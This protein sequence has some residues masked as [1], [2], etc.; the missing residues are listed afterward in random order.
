MRPSSW[1]T[2]LPL[3]SGMSNAAMILRANATSAAAA[4]TRR[5]QRRSDRDGSASC[6]R[7]RAAALL[8]FASKPSSVAEVVVDAVE[9]GEAVGARGRQRRRQPVEP[10]VRSAPVARAFP[11]RDRWCPSR[12]T[13]R[14]EPAW[15]RRAGDLAALR[16]ASGVSIMAQSFMGRRRLLTD[17][18]TRGRFRSLGRLDLGSRIGVGRRRRRRRRDRRRP[19][20]CRGR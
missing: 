4:R 17:A 10:A 19:M 20:A 3:F 13:A 5:W 18:A 7:S 9:N 16:I 8:A 2:P 14:R 15:S 11:W 12:S 6:R 1:M